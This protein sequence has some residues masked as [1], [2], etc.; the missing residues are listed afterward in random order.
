MADKNSTVKPEPT[1]VVKKADKATEKVATGADKI[2]GKDD[3]GR[4]I[5]EGARGGRYYINSN[6]NRTYVK[7]DN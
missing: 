5:Y 3:K 6:G 7:K 1:K 2:F 4:T